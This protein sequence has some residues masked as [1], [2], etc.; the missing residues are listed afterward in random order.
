VTISI[1]VVMMQGKS[2]GGI[3]ALLKTADKALY[4]A[5]EQGRNCVVMA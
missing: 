3:D 1:G 5:K 2:E 4:R